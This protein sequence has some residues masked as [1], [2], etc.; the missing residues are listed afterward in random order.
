MI[1]FFFELTEQEF[2]FCSSTVC[3]LG[4]VASFIFGHY[5][6]LRLKYMEE[7]I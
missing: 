7:I 5:R 6:I 3:T 2:F 4:V 1:F